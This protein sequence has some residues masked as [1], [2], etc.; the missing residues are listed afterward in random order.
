MHK[1]DFTKYSLA[2][3]KDSKLIFS[4]KGTGI[5]P[6]VDC[7]MKLKKES[8]NIKDCILHD[9]V[10]GLAAA[11]LIVYSKMISEVH[12]GTISKDAAVM[13]EKEYIEV[14]AEKGVENILSRDRSG[15]CPMEEL[16]RKVPDNKLFFLELEDKIKKSYC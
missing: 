13:L 15:P 11:R 5:R 6:L 2:L 7:I 9:K 12:A 10:I 1:A 16:A 14:E 8:P 4:S 3:Y